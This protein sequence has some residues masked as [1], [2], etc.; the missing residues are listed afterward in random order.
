MVTYVRQNV[1]NCT[2]LIV[3]PMLR[4]IKIKNSEIGLDNYEQMF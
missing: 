1:K 4:L 3:V 2:C